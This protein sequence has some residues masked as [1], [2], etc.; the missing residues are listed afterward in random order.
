MRISDSS[1]KDCSM[2]Y[3]RKGKRKKGKGEKGKGKGE[4]G[5]G[6]EKNI[7]PAWSFSPQNSAQ[8][9]KVNSKW[10]SKDPIQSR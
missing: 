7:S 5:K 9:H 4:R 6:K 1:I 10:L 3:K 8:A 2:Y